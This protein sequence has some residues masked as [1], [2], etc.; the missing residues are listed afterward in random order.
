M[1]SSRLTP[2][3]YQQKTGRRPPNH[4]PNQRKKGQH[5]K[6]SHMRRRSLKVPI[7]IKRG[8]T[9]PHGINGGIVYCIS[10]RCTGEK[11]CGNYRCRRRIFKCRHGWFYDLAIRR[12]DD[13][14]N[15]LDRSGET[16]RIHLTLAWKQIIH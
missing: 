13:W 16:R 15:D 10:E 11:I 14:P 1:W 6:D 4:Q 2:I 8:F 9:L 12:R 5:V 7:H 3:L